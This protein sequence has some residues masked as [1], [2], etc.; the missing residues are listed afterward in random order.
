MADAIDSDVLTLRHLL[1]LSRLAPRDLDL[2]PTFAELKHLLR[3]EADC[4]REARVTED[5]G[6]RLSGDTH[7]IVP[8]IYPGYSTAR[9]LAMRYK[10]G[11]GVLDASVQALP[12][13]RRNRLALIEL[14]LREF[15]EWG[16][17]QSDPNFGNVRFRLDPA[18][19][20]RMLGRC[21]PR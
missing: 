16:M 13:E 17:V 5:Y 7:F 15:F 8:R 3:Q 18:G 11:P 20:D 6:H 4:A 21:G 10:K 9:V 19:Q 14:F 12:L 2:T 1:M